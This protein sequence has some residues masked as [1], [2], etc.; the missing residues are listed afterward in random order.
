M[1]K[2]VRHDVILRKCDESVSMV[3]CERTDIHTDI[4]THTL[5]S[6]TKYVR[7]DVIFRKCDESVYR[8][9]NEPKE[10]FGRCLITKRQS[11]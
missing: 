10:I 9:C 6:M 7:H 11:L 3:K 1:T 4:H 8:T 2:Y 5:L